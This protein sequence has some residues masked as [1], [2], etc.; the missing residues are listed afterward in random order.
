MLFWLCQLRRVH[1]SL[2]TE[3]IKTLFLI[4]VTSHVDYCNSVLAFAPKTNMDQLQQILNAT[5]RFFS[6]II[7]INIIIETFVMRL[8]QLKTNTSATYAKVK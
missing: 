6:I 5:A 8:L 3:S 1:R 2:D 4:L 7:I